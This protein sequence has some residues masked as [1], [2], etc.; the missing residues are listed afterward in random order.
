MISDKLKTA[1]EK[2]YFEDFDKPLIIKETN[3][4]TGGCINNAV[5][6]KTSQGLY[7]VKWNDEK[8]YPLMFEAEMKGLQHLFDTHCIRIPKPLFT[9]VSDDMSFIFMAYVQA[10]PPIKNFWENFGSSLALLHKNSSDAFGLNHDNYIGSLPQSN[11]NHKSWTDFF[12]NERLEKL[13][14][15]AY[16]NNLINSLLIKHFEHL[17]LRLAD[18]FPEELPALL[19]GDLWNGNYIVGEDGKAFII[20]PAVYYGHREMDLGMTKL[21]GGFT[22][23]FYRSYDNTYPLEKGWTNRIEIC[24]LYP[25]LVHLNLFGRS[26]L[27]GIESV[28][29]R[30]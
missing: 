24:N 18:I 5:M 14:V 23:E 10:S 17:Y 20:D 19:H 27:S 12:V 7:F 22:A 25:L 1:I 15:L 8:K 21:F 11:K 26:Y 6:L 28:V 4:V 16:D 9:G 2:K 3:S 30:F 29:R 13:V